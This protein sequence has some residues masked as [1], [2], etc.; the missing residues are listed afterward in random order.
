M[1]PKVKASVIKMVCDWHRDKLANDTED[2][3]GT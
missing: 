2:S 1:L 3:P